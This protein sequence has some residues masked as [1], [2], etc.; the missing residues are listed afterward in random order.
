M[1]SFE[2]V[3]GLAWPARGLRRG[4][5]S[6]LKQIRVEVTAVLIIKVLLQSV[7]PSTH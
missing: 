2:S 1:G 6:C 5:D 3:S 7:L 4:K